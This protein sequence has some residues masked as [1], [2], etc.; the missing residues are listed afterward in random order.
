MIE[1]LLLV[2]L[3]FSL[4]A[5]TYYAMTRYQL[6][7]VTVNAA[8]RDTLLHTVPFGMPTII[9]FSTPTCAACNFQQT[10]ILTQVQHEI[11]ERLHVIKVDA[12]QDSDAA[13]RWGVFSVP[14]TFV[15]DGKGKPH[16]VYNGVVSVEA[17]RRAVEQL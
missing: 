12:T 8:Q 7:R 10:P 16:Q 14:T 6:T 3:L 17:L 11:G 4:G 5:L 2:G 1:R 15:V 13:T 9:S